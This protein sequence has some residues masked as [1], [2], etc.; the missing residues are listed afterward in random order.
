MYFQ[1]HSIFLLIFTISIFWTS[2]VIAESDIRCFS[3]NKACQLVATSLPLRALPKSMSALYS[4]P[5]ISS[6]ILES[7]VKA[8]WPLY[9]FERKNVNLTRNPA[10]GWYQVGQQLK[11]AKGW[12][13]AKDILEWKHALVIAYSHP[14]LG[15]ERRNTVLMFKTKET[16][17]QLVEAEE[18]E[19]IE[20]IYAGL[21]RKPPIIHNDLVSREPMR[22]VSIDEKFYMLPIINFQ[23]V[24]LFLDETRYLQIAAAIPGERGTADKPDTVHNTAFMEQATS[25]ETIIGTE[26]DTLG[27]DIKF[28]IDMTGSMG[29]YIKGTRDAIAKVATMISQI[30][31]DAQVRYGLI[32]Y[33]DDIKKIPAL[34]FTSK[35]F[36]EHLIDHK[37]FQKVIATAK[38]AD[39]GSADYQE[40]VFAGIKEALYS[41]WNKNTIRF[42]ILIGDASSHQVGHPQNTTGFNATEIRKLATLHKVNIIAIHLKAARASPDHEL[43][44][45]QFTTLS[46]NPG[47]QL[48]SYLEVAAEKH[49]DFEKAVKQVAKT[50]SIFI[51]EVRQ[52]NLQK[53]HDVPSTET[54]SDIEDVGDKAEVIAQSIAAAALVDYLGKEAHPPKDITAWVMD[55]DLLNPDIMALDVRVLLKKRELNDLIR[56][57]EDIQKA[58]KRAELTGMGFFSALQGVIARSTQNKKISFKGAKKLAKTGILPAWIEALPYKSQILEMSDDMFVELRAQDRIDLERDI[59]SKLELYRKVNENSDVWVNLEEQNANRNNYVYPLPLTALP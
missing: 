6:K 38:A 4:K 19:L 30:N 21:K 50:L 37:E 53:L 52:G 14:G 22:F 54:I 28:V 8:F 40:E 31:M 47:S 34:A 32:G 5:D 7:N 26:V 59:D 49:D 20:E 39:I 57:L 3:G 58:V 25:A 46:L 36:T 13:Q 33:R 10:T 43:A 23:T 12:M 9:V 15:E 27:F 56:S 17:N 55:R 18:P 24:D 16:L 41:T 48:S 2:N 45:T 29:P 44:E 1:K 51:S 11:T 35:N 42:I